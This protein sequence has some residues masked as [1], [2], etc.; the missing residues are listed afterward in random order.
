MAKRNYYRKKKKKGKQQEKKKAEAHSAI[1]GSREALVES[2]PATTRIEF[3]CGPVKWSTT[4]S[5]IVGT[6][7]KM[8]VIF[9]GAWVPVNHTNND[10]ELV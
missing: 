2:W 8:L 3:G 4:S 6:L 1:Y 9:S 10:M 5:T 7:F